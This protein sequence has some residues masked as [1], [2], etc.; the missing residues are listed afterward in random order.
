MPIIDTNTN[1][2]THMADLKKRGV[3]AIGR[4]YSSSAWKRLTKAEAQAIS[5]A[6][7]KIFVVFEND[8]DPALTKAMGLKHAQIAVTQ[9]QAV[10]QPAG[11]AIY[12]ALEHL[13][14]G[15]EAKHVPGIK[16]YVAGLTEGLAG[17]YALGIYSD[18]VVCEALRAGGLCKYTWLSASRGF[19]GSKAYY[20]A[21]K[22]NLAQ[23]PHVDQN[24][25][26]VSV[27]LNEAK[28]EFGA[29]AV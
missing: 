25:D 24:W 14:S 29:F 5:K 27:D 9:A 1:V 15:Y 19:P 13:P 4:Y 23:D 21:G 22:W 16:L 11:S 18:G 28:G 8:G 20:A 12:F 2:T 26:G 7:V 3:T 17:K 6:G 10:G